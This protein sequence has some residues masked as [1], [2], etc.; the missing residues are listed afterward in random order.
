MADAGS[1]D[2]DHDRGSHS[3]GDNEGDLRQVPGLSN[4]DGAPRPSDNEHASP[5][6]APSS[7]IAALNRLREA[8][9]A[10]DEN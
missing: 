4:A 5:R 2:R 9:T 6:Q 1:R 8:A 7:V 10:H 3:P